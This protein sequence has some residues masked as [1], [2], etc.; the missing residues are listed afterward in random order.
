MG[1]RKLANTCPKLTRKPLVRIQT[2]EGLAH[3]RTVFHHPE[4]LKRNTERAGCANWC[5]PGRGRTV[6]HS[7]SELKV[8]D[9]PKVIG[10]EAGRH[11]TWCD[12]VLHANDVQPLREDQVEAL[13]WSR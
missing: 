2:T 13:E 8:G 1:P 7:V 5:Y 4:S 11:G 9:D 10:A 3:D 12:D 6:A